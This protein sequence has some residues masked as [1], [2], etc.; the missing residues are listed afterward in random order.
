MEELSS[1]KIDFSVHCLHIRHKDM[2]VLSVPNPGDDQFY[3]AYDSA[4]YWCI[5][6]QTNFGPDG[7]PVRP[8]CCRDERGCCAHH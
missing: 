7:H 8:D 1:R 5:K 4:A 3:D 2:Y 6:T